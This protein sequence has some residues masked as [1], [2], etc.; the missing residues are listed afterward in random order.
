MNVRKINYHK[1][2][3]S[4]T[5]SSPP[6]SLDVILLQRL[7]KSHITS[8]TPVTPFFQTSS[9]T[10]KWMILSYFH[11]HGCLLFEESYV[12][13]VWIRSIWKRIWSL[14]NYSFSFWEDKREIFRSDRIFDYLYLTM[15][16]SFLNLRFYYSTLISWLV[17]K[18]SMLIT[19]MVRDSVRSV[20]SFVHS[21]HFTSKECKWRSGT[22]K[23]RLWWPKG[24]S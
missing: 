14:H 10:F 5:S 21:S 3:C 6:A 9:C 4:S 23:W 20:S 7:V 16:C 19:D 13:K 2:C 18:L 17:I 22:L 11:D 24:N 15:I 12:W 8:I 1:G